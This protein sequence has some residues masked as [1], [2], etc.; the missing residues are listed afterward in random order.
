MK[1][2]PNKQET[3][4]SQTKLS[5]SDTNTSQEEQ[6]E[7]ES[8]DDEFE[9]TE[10]NKP[11]DPLSTVNRAITVFND[12]LFIYGLNPIS[13]VYTNTMPK[14][15]RLGLHN[16]LHNIQFPIRFIN[17]L[18]QLKFKNSV[19]ELGRFIVNS[20][21][22]FGGLMDPATHH[23]HIPVHNEDFGQTLGHYGV[24]PGFHI[25][26]P[27]FGPSNLRDFIGFSVDGYTSPL[28]YTKDLNK[29][30]IPKNLLESIGISSVKAISWGSLHLGEYESIK[31]D[32]LDLYPFLRD[33]YEQKRLAD[34]EE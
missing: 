13:Q 23:L 20:T 10:A 18:L 30:R 29:V 3:L 31:K 15:V 19:E 6:D 12:K 33:V 27:L 17:N 25:V 22:G 7:E 21:V 9:D 16:F 1:L 28:V 11:I 14:F 5:L 26:L 32:A 4:S 8:F 24:G 34:I 2:S